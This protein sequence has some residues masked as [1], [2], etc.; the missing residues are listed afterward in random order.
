LLAAETLGDAHA[1]DTGRPAATLVLAAWRGYEAGS[2]MGDPAEPAETLRDERL[3]DVWAR[4]GVLVNELARPAL[5]LN[6]PVRASAPPL[7]APG[8][9]AYASLRLLL[10]APPPWSVAGR[11]VHVCENPNLLAIAAD[12]LGRR[13]APMLCTDGMPA[14]AQRILLVQLAEAGATLLYHGDF[15]WAGLHIAN[16]V[17]SAY[18]ARPWRFGTED[19]VAAVTRRSASGHRLIGPPVAASWDAVLASTMLSFDLAVPEEAVAGPLIRDL[20]AEATG[21]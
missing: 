21:P 12:Q 3:R 16:H 11:A 1:L 20:D 2:D 17:F 14:A 10:R 19:Y 6:M 13:C 18:G 8:E 5:L 9:P 15:D 4:A 7:A